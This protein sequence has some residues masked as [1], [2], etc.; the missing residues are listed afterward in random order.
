MK[1]MSVIFVACRGL[2]KFNGIVDDE[3]RSLHLDEDAVE[4]D[5]SSDWPYLADGLEVGAAYMY[6]EDCWF[7]GFGKERRFNANLEKLA[8]FVAYDWRMPGADEPGPFRE[9]FRWGGEGMIGPIAAAK[10]VADF[11]DYHERAQ[12]LNDEEFYAF[13]RNM[14]A[15]FEFAMNDGCVFHRCS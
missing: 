12:A 15:M 13:Y 3:F 4:V 7:G 10:L 8:N 9:L 14:R 5:S 6:E 11:T 1:Q 2:T